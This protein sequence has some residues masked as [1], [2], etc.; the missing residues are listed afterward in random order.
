[1]SAGGLYALFALG[2]ALI[3]GVMD[4]INF[5]HGELIMVGGYALFYFSGLPW[6]VIGAG[7]ILISILFALGIERVAF[8]PVRGSTQ[9]TLLITSF[10]VSFFLQNL[11]LMVVGGLPKSV[12]VLNS[13]SGSLTIGPFHVVKLSVVTIATTIVLVT[14]LAVFLR[15]TSLGIQMRAAADDFP[16]ARLLGVKA[17]TVVATAFA[18]SGLLAG[19]ASILLVAQ[20]GTLTPYM[21]L[22][23][24]LFAFVAT[25]IGGIG[26]L[27]GAVVGGFVLGALT[28]G[29]QTALSIGLRSYRD[30]FVFGGVIALLIFFP[31]GL[32][33]IRHSRPAMRFRQWRLQGE[34]G[35][36]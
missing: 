36:T 32:A 7:A 3:F 10:A 22:T 15:R 8:R 28:V 29:L 14:A 24:V 27:P 2:I 21:G 11:A 33:G 23:P 25:I 31:N 17:N 6:P 4:L 19:V 20:T 30:A 34:G 5:A 1:M 26:S 16:M 35:R 9:T 13:L 12:A 18:L